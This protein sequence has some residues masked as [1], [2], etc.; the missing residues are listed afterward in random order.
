MT[1]ELCTD[2]GGTLI[3]RTNELRIVL[4]DDTD[5]PGFCRVIWNAHTK[6]MTDLEPAQMA[7]FMGA[8]FAVEDAVRSVLAPD[9]INLASLGNMTPHLHWHVVPRYAADAHFPNPIWGARQREEDEAA[10]SVRRAKLVQ[11][12]DEIRSRLPAAQL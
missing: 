1:C 4:V 6:E 9:K 7:R 12:S 11:L 10:R 3:L 5:H 2:D 8:V